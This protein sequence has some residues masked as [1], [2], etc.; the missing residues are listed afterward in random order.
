MDYRQQYE[1]TKAAVHIPNDM[2]SNIVAKKCQQ[3]LSDI[4]YRTY[5]HRWTCLPDEHDVIRAKNAQ[6]ILSDVC[7]RSLDLWVLPISSG[8]FD[9]FEGLCL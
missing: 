1:H 6:E 9:K 4:E 3:I 5:H 7:I 8:T 2:I